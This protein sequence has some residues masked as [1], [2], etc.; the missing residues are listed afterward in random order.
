MHPLSRTTVLNY[1]ASIV[2]ELLQQRFESKI[3]Q[4]FSLKILQNQKPA[5]SLQSVSERLVF[6]SPNNRITESPKT[7]MVVFSLSK[8][9]EKSEYINN[10]NK[11]KEKQQP[12]VFLF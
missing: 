2:A 1:K 9:F 11:V 4:I 8:F 12:S 7:T 10:Q 3:F 5:I 6:G